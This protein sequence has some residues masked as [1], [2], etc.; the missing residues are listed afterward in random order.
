MSLE[1][2]QAEFNRAV[3]RFE[4]EPAYRY[5]GLGVAAA[6]VS[7]QAALLWRALNAGAGAAQAL[8]AAAA[9]YVAADFVNGLVHMYQ[10]NN[11]DYTSVAGPFNA[12][13][14][15]HHKIPRYTDRPLPLVYFLESGSK[16]WL[17]PVQAVSAW[18]AFQP[19]AS[20]ALVWFLAA[21]GILSSVA[22]VSHYLAH[23]SLSRAAAF[24]AACGLLLSKRHHGRHH[25]SDNASYAFLNGM[26]DP[27]LDRIAARLYGGYK[28]GTDLHYARYTA[29]ARK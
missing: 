13:F 12:A 4:K 18:Y 3:E 27:V 9:A 16:V 19:G 20:P 10:D 23:N 17:V 15:L 14:H 29:T 28:N 5:F 22:E 2:K 24:L 11:E 25:N 7:L 6:N 1:E 26:T 21:F 8:A